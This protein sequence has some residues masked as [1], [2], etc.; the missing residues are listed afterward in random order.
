MNQLLTVSSLLS[1]GWA[2]FKKSWKFIVP[3]SILTLLIVIILRVI[4]NSL[5]RHM[6][7]GIIFTIISIIV[8][9]AISLGWAK[10]LLR[11]IRGESVSQGDFKTNFR[12]WKGYVVAQI[13]YTIF[14]VI[15][16]IF[17]IPTVTAI[18]FA[19]MGSAKMM[20]GG[21]LPIVII[22]L[23]IGIVLMVW[24]AIRYVFIVFIASDYPTLSGWKILKKSAAMT[25][26]NMWKIFWY[27]IVF[28]LVNLLGL[29]CIVIGLFATVP[30]TKLAM[31]KFYDSLK[32]KTAE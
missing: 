29:I 20:L 24:L 30:T 19:G 8:S 7:I 27:G 31:T 23:I 25:K 3:A 9:I 11:L 15:A 10:V 5:D 21:N 6:G 14:K 16:L 22:T 17:F 4:Q 18:I 28:A 32:E 1:T 2:T 12:N 13:I 26:G